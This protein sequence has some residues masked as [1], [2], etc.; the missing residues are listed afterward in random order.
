[1]RAFRVFAY[2]LCLIVI[3]AGCS[4]E[5]GRRAPDSDAAGVVACPPFIPTCP[6]GQRVADVDGDGCALE[7]APIACPPFIPT[8]PEGQ[9]VADVDGD[10]CALECAPIACPPFIPTCPEGQRVADVD[11]DGCALECQ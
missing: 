9:R 3:A 2:G 4:A 1:M 7:C 8:C 10:G 5:P 6:E 11:G